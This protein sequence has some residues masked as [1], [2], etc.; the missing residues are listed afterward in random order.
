[1]TMT[2]RNRI[3]FTEQEIANLTLDN[4]SI[5]I[6]SLRGQLEYAEGAGWVRKPIGG[7]FPYVQMEEDSNGNIIYKG[8]NG[9]L[10]ATDAQ[11]DW[12][13]FKY[14]WGTTIPTK[15]QMRVTSWT[16]RSSGW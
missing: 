14:T 3:G 2:D 6:T 1:M 11:T 9:S 12:I 13:I 16:N 15:I 7:C 5:G 8:I 4:Q 10:S